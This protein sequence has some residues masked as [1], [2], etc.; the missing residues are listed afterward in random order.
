[1]EL[2]LNN[3]DVNKAI[4][5]YVEGLGMDLSDKHVY[6]NT[7]Q[8]RKGDGG[9]EATITFS[10]SLIDVLT[11]A[12]SPKEDNVTELHKETPVVEETEEV[13]SNNGLFS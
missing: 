8:I 4:R 2:K 5:Q 11:T 1:M 10:D 9:T 6:V 7:S 12:T 3:E 13:K